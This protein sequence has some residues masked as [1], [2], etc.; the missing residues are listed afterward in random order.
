MPRTAMSIPLPM[1]FRSDPESLSNASDTL[2]QNLFT[3]PIDMAPGS[4]IRWSIGLVLAYILIRLVQW[5]WFYKSRVEVIHSHYSV[6]VP[7]LDSDKRKRTLVEYLKAKVPSLFGPNAYF[8]PHPYIR[9][10]VNLTLALISLI[11]S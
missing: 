10:Y 2:G 4:Y 3:L 8:K 9:G 5:I 11:S 7:S 1:W 6:N